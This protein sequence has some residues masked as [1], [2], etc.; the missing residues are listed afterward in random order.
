MRPRILLRFAAVRRVWVLWGTLAVPRLS[1]HPVL[2][3]GRYG[4]I[5]SQVVVGAGVARLVARVDLFWDR[6]VCGCRRSC[7]A[8][9]FERPQ[10]LPSVKRGVQAFR[11]FFK[12]KADFPTISQP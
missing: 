3:L 6:L 10:F 12:A 1:R 7:T 11:S 5:R 2:L 4:V 8:L 9:P